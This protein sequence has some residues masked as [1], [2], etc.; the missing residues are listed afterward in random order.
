[1]CAN[2]FY[3]Q[4]GVYDAFVEKFAAASKAM[5]VGNGLEDGVVQGPLIEEKRSRKWSGC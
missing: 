2:R 3:V 4:A 5:K 1:M